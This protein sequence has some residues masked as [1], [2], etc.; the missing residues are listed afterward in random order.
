MIASRTR[1]A[2]SALCLFASVTTGAGCSSEDA[3]QLAT[4]DAAISD[5]GSEGAPADGGGADFGAPSDAYPAY[6]PP[7]LPTALKRAPLAPVLTDFTV[8]P[9]V[10]AGDT[11]AANVPDF[12]T[13]YAASAEWTA[14]VAEYGVGN[15]TVGATVTLAE[16]APTTISD[17]EIQAWLRAKL[18]GTHAEWGATDDATLRRTIFLLMYPRRTTLTKEA[19]RKSCGDFFGYHSA[20]FP[21][22][23]FDA[24]LPDA[25]GDRSS[26]GGGPDAADDASIGDGGADAADDGSAE[27]G[28]ADAAAASTDGDA[29]DAA[30]AWIDGG[31]ARTPILYAPIARCTATGA[32][33]ADTTTTFIAHE[34]IESATN[35]Y[36]GG[37]L[38]VD[39]D[40]FPWSIGMHGG[41]IADLCNVRGSL[42]K[43]PSIG[44][45]IARAWSNAAA[46]VHHDPCVPGPPG[47]PYFNSFIVP[48]DKFQINDAPTA[49][50]IGGVRVP[51]GDTRTVD[52]FLFSDRATPGPGRVMVHEVP[53]IS[54]N[55]PALTL[56]LDRMSGVN[57]EKVHL[58]ITANNAVSNGVTIVA[59]FSTIG[60]RTS[61]WFTPVSVR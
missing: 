19:G 48:S 39:V 27:D 1:A 2:C 5:A 9:V 22:P 28:A 31:V 59:L 7:P 49:P 44:Y 8:V 47:E 58:T 37:Y 14:S 11:G 34:V 24:G 52:V 13:R 32:T 50:M 33:E 35:P 43:P 3:A 23:V 17:R 26:D 25:A 38:L 54:S 42:W 12:L 10:F 56:A 61:L 15:M 36:G 18:D 6:T 4:A 55:P 29:A 46:S 41:E 30:G 40:H 21:Q 45:A 53:M 57:G 16:P 51:V 60:T 20:I